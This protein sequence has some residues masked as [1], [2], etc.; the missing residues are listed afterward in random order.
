LLENDIDD[1]IDDEEDSVK[2]NKLFKEEKLKIKDIDT[3]SSFEEQSEFY[4]ETDNNNIKNN[5]IISIKDKVD[6]VDKN[7]LLNI[8]NKIKENN[9]L[10]RQNSD[11]KAKLTKIFSEKILLENEKK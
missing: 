1:D 10:K 2:E 8:M 4:K 7:N 5:K 3:I 9:I 6:K 11:L